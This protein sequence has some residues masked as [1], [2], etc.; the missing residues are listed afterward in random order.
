MEERE[1]ITMPRNKPN[2][3]ALLTVVCPIY[4]ILYN[5][6]T[7]YLKASYVPY[8]API[9]SISISYE[10]KI[11]LDRSYHAPIDAPRAPPTAAPVAT[12]FAHC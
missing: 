12:L 2:T 3:A 10:I 11:D 6:G 5:P 7:L 1:T 8:I 9:I 4:L